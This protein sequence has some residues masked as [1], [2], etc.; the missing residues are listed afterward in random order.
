MKQN[1]SATPYGE[2]IKNLYQNT[3]LRGN[4][5]KSKG[6]EAEAWM[7]FLADELIYGASGRIIRLAWTVT[8]VL[9]P[10]ICEKSVSWHVCF[11]FSRDLFCF[12]VG[13]HRGRWQLGM[14]KPGGTLIRSVSR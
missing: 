2:K 11:V 9:C 7:L 12:V 8:A 6:R 14:L 10:K 5:S 3:P 1:L 4:G 13:L